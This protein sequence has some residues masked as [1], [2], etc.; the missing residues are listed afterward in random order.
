MVK[1]I[2]TSGM[3]RAA[4]CA[5]PPR[6]AGSI[7]QRKR[8]VLAEGTC[9][10]LSPRPKRALACASLFLCDMLPRAGASAPLSAGP[11]VRQGLRGRP[12]SHPPALRV[13]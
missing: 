8:G 1:E 6:P 5:A 9:K 10:A 7:S 2:E 12:P 3:L 4:S 11:P 13:H